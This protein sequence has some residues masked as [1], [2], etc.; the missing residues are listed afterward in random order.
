M[1]NDLCLQGSFLFDDL[2]HL[3]MSI[4]NF[5]PGL[6]EKLHFLLVSSFFQYV[7][8]LKIIDRTSI[9]CL[10]LILFS[11]G[12]L[13]FI[14]LLEDFHGMLSLQFVMSSRCRFEFTTGIGVSTVRQF[15]IESHLLNLGVSFV[16][17]I[18]CGLSLNVE[19]LVDS[20]DLISQM[21]CNFLRHC[22]HPLQLHTSVCCSLVFQRHLLNCRILSMKHLFLH[23]NV[24]I[25]K[26][27]TLTHGFDLP[28]Y[29][30][31]YLVNCFSLR[32]LSRLCS[33]LLSYHF[34]LELTLH[35]KM[36]VFPRLYWRRGFILGGSQR[37]RHLWSHKVFQLWQRRQILKS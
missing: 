26:C 24:L 1:S 18:F 25:T 16:I 20:H 6:I 14:F 8:S 5:I 17:Y 15:K 31:F 19:L 11:H 36:L 30:R 35:T 3:Q 7:F 28:I 32:S 9:D 12:G 10:L 37:P 23:S 34:S 2:I 29:G 27:D 4:V 33:G 22:V 21:Y 13:T